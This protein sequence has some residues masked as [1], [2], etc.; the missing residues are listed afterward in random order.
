[1]GTPLAFAIINKTSKPNLLH[2]P[3]SSYLASTFRKLIH[4]WV[5]DIPL[6]AL[7]FGISRAILLSW[8]NTFLLESALKAW[9]GTWGKLYK[10]GFRDYSVLRDHVLRRGSRLR[11]MGLNGLLGR[12]LC[13]L[14]LWLVAGDFCFFF[15]LLYAVSR[16]SHVQRGIG[17][18]A[19]SG[20]NIYSEWMS[21]RHFVSCRTSKP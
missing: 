4:W 21:G 19:F 7:V 10:R 6:I 15:S 20:Q 3:C 9:S 1:M 8:S 13:V 16:W 14:A 2:L 5:S 17:A 18:L 11:C 12:E